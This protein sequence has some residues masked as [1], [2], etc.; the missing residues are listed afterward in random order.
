MNDKNLIFLHIPKAAGSTLY[1]VI[2]R[3]YDPAVIYT[4]DGSRTWE[5]M[6]EFASLPDERRRKIRVLKGH[7]T[8]GMHRYLFGPST[9]IT[10][11]RDPVERII[12]HYYYVLR[13]PVHYLYD[14][15]KSG[16]MTLKDYVQSRL[17]TELDNGQTRLIC[18]V[19]DVLFGDEE[20]EVPFG[21]CSREML[22]IAKK[23]LL[24]HFSVVGLTERF[25]ETLVLLKRIFGWRMPFYTMRNVT[26]NR[27]RKESID[28]ETLALIEKQNKLD[29]EL[30]RFAEDLFKR[31]IA[32]QGSSFEKEVRRFQA[33]NAVYSKIGYVIK[34]AQRVR[35]RFGLR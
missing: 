13:T 29:L 25:D 19:K 24:D 11:L 9:Y 6:K 20:D 27:P 32:E 12:S 21:E 22:E 35:R 5:S 2:D 1:P 3:H 33:I 4:I 17:S 18:G 8:F 23:N 15:V 14:K 10:L 7:M 28:R 30:Y 31:K 34:S 16:N 26:K